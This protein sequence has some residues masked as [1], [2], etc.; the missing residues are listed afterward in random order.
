MP[1]IRCTIRD[2]G[3]D[4]TE[5]GG[6]DIGRVQDKWKTTVDHWTDLVKWND[7][8][9][10]GTGDQYD[11]SGED[12]K[13]EG[14]WMRKLFREQTRNGPIYGCEMKA[15][16][17]CNGSTYCRWIGAQRQGVIQEVEKN[18][19]TPQGYQRNWTHLGSFDL[20]NARVPFF[21]DASFVNSPGD[22]SQLVYVLIILDDGKVLTPSIFLQRDVE[23]KPEEWWPARS[24]L[25][26]KV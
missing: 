18:H 16:C 9:E 14:D 11:A 15:W 20:E 3:I 10:R 21:S 2:K 19:R 6:R 17:A 5:W 26:K 1:H 7:P 4:I 8:S 22:R 24:M 25:Q 12:R 13:N 23:G